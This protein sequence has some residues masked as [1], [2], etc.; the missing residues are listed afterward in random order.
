[1]TKSR[2]ILAI[3]GGGFATTPRNIVFSRYLLELTEKR[4]PRLCYIPTASGDGEVRIG[5]F[6]QAMATHH[7]EATASHISLFH[8]E[9][10]LERAVAEAD[11][12][13]VGGGNT[14]NMLLL[15][16]AWG[17]DSLLRQAYES[18]KILA[19]HSAGANCWFEQF[20]TDSTGELDMMPGLGWLKG[21][22]CPH[23][24][25]EEK[26]PAAYRK[27]LNT[28]GLAGWAADDDAAVHFIN[29]KPHRLLASRK[30]A[31]THQFTFVKDGLKEKALKPDVLKD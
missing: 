8:R 4:R 6:Y 18:G 2:H 26:R 31:R 25:S 3:G 15:W 13:Y 16:K 27:S 12:L 22:F 21:A 7:P 24:D 29:E 28:L 10:S 19:G 5:G 17:L 1:M 14:F 20:L 23:F 9:G 30:D 11:V